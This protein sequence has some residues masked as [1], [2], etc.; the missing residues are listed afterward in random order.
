MPKASGRGAL[1]AV[2][3]RLLAPLPRFPLA[4]ALT[5]AVRD[6]ARRRPELFER[7][8]AFADRE[9]A[10][11]PSDLPFA[12]V[13]EPRVTDARVRV[14]DHDE[15]ERAA[16]RIRATLLVL[17]GLLDG[18]YDGDA[19]FFSRDLVVEGETGAIVALR[20]TLEDAELTP[21][22]LAGL[23]GVLGRLLD[24]AAEDGLALARRVCHAPKASKPTAEA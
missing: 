2:V 9:I 4:F 24:R 16:A 7:L 17:L 11:I 21:A 20:N 3:T 22:E 8:E 23:R 13:I 18:T 10:V 19:L 14:V 5:R 12:F 15:A 1:P 6:L